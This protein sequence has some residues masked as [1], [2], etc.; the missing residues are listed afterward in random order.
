[1]PSDRLFALLGDDHVW[2][3]YELLEDIEEAAFRIVLSSTQQATHPHI[4]VVRR[5]AR[6]HMDRVLSNEEALRREDTYPIMELGVVGE[7]LG[8]WDGLPPHRR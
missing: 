4:E 3:R 6:Q 2:T 5:L 1:M 7:R 8:Y